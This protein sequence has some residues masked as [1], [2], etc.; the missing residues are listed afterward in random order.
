LIE[1]LVISELTLL[2]TIV[3]LSLGAMVCLTFWLI[4]QHSIFAFLIVVWV[5]Y[6]IIVV[7]GS[8][9]VLYALQKERHHWLRFFVST[10][11]LFGSLVQAEAHDQ[12]EFSYSLWSDPYHPEDHP[13]EAEL[14]QPNLQYSTRPLD[15]PQQIQWIREGSETELHWQPVPEASEYELA[16]L[17]HPDCEEG[18][19]PIYQGA[20]T[21]FAVKEPG[22]FRVRSLRITPLDDPVYERISQIL[23]DTAMPIP[24]IGAVY[25]LRDYSD[26]EYVFIVAPAMDANKDGYIDPETERLA[27][28]GELYPHETSVMIPPGVRTPLITEEPV[29]DVWGTWY[30]AVVAID[31]P[32]G[33]R[34]GY[35]GVDYPVET[36]EKNVFQT[37]VTYA[38]FLVVALAMYFFGVIQMTKLH[39]TSEAQKV[40]AN[41]LHHT[42][43][44]LTEAKKMAEAAARA[45]GY[46]LTNMSHE[47]RTPM[48]AVLG[49]TGIIDWSPSPGMLSAGPMRRQSANHSFDRKKQFGPIDHYQRH[50]RFLQGRCRSSRD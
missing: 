3:L 35:V 17:A 13:L 41:N 37:Q 43:E 7:T 16:W 29:V 32:D 49:F 28:I 21:S 30:S 12:I 44:E 26:E 5:G 19:V 46:F 23:V 27:P 34:E 38:I 47:I 48:N 8:S 39:L 40:T 2:I 6:V 14:P 25:T 20:E 18:W 45:K 31:R 33:S 42:I 4:R 1:N 15:I 36:W 11:Q 50:S 10:C 9:T 24:S 22:W